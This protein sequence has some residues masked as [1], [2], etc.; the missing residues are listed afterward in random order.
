MR[1]PNLPFPLMTCLSKIQESPSETSKHVPLELLTWGS[2]MTRFGKAAWYGFRRAA[3]SI[4]DL[5]RM[6][7]EPRLKTG[8]IR[9][10]WKCVRF[11]PELREQL[12]LTISGAMRLD[13]I[14]RLCRGTSRSRCSTYAGSRYSHHILVFI[15]NSSNSKR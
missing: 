10:R 9:M 15:A 1:Q 11:S 6:S 8:C 4:F 14:L 12:S 7:L 2:T 5:C 13:I 3:C